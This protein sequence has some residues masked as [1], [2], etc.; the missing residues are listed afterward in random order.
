MS[1]QYVLGT[2][3]EETERLGQQHQIWHA[4]T[5]A[6][7]GMA[8]FGPGQSLLDAGCGPG[9]ATADLA[10]LVGPNGQVHALDNAQRFVDMAQARAQALGLK[11]VDVVCMDV[12]DLTLAA[13]SFDGVFLRWV[14]S[15]VAEPGP[16]V[17]RLCAALKPAGA[18]VA[19]DY[20][21][22]RAARLYPSTDT[23]V[24]L[25]DYFGEANRLSGG[26]YDHGDGLAEMAIHA[27]L[28][29]RYLEPVVFAARP[30][31]RYWHWF[32]TF[33]RVFIPSMV[34]SGQMPAD[35][36]RR[37]VE[38]LRERETLPGAYFMT[39]PVMKMIAVKPR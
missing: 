27:G 19:M 18:L 33:C 35:F 22:Y 16:G 17:Q 10:N 26:S 39:P 11:Q 21:N 23:L 3:P 2:H 15:F 29:V 32:T 5:T 36:A 1:D 20:C 37:V 24:E 6:L 9:F 8:G 30:G 31:D 13:E 14:L 4:A 12:T 28:D 25:F 34:E 38:Q 7:W